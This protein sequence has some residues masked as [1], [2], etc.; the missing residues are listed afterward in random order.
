MPKHFAEATIVCVPSQRAQSGDAEGLPLVCVEAMLSSCALAATKHA[1]IPECV[2][3]GK[4]G[5]LVDERDDVALADRIGR[6]LDDP[7]RTRA[8]GEAGRALAL[9]RFNLQKLSHRLQDHLL[10]VAGEKVL[11][12]PRG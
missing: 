6:M 1:G 12:G 2:E 11:A 8:M 4:T 5:Y 10:R 7:A 9:D 3:D